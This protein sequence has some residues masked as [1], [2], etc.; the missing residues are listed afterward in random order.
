MG[1]LLEPG[2]AGGTGTPPGSAGRARLLPKAFL[3]A[4]ML[5]LLYAP[6]PTPA[7]GGLPTVL[8]VAFSSRVFSDVDRN[9]ARIAMELWARELSRKAGI[10]QAQV[11]I[12]RQVDEISDALR[13]GDIHIVTL[14]SLEYI[15]HRR[16]LAVVPAYVAA[17]KSGSDMENLLLVRRDSGI[18]S[19]RDLKGRIIGMLPAAKS[20]TGRLWINVLF[21]KEIGRPAGEFFGSIHEVPKASQAVMGV[22]FRKLDGAVVTRGAYETCRILNPQLARDMAIIAQSK[23]LASDITCLPTA[24]DP[25]MRQAI[26][27]AA[28]T[29]HESA[30]G[31]QMATL[32]QINRVVPFRQEDL[33]GIAELVRDY[34]S[35]KGGTSR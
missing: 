24:I 26:D 33:A 15:G 4:A 18:R 27:R 14:S 1:V 8:H 28:L 25:Q 10:P 12:F 30:V 19:T 32:F 7:A 21:M 3:A 9:D 22:F 2:K 6:G 13:R 29:L 34:A 20:E 31:K 23:S 35:L 16:K 5:L 17:N 11:T